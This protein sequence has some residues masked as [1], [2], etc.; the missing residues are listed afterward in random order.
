MLDAP[1]ESEPTDDEFPVDSSTQLKSA[2]RGKAA[3]RRRARR[4]PAD[5]ERSWAD[6]F[7]WPFRKVNSFLSHWGFGQLA[8]IGLGAFVGLLRR[9]MRFR[10]T[11]STVVETDRE[12]EVIAIPDRKTLANPLWWCLWTFQFPLTWLVSRPFVGLVLSVPAVAGLGAAFLVLNRGAQI[13][14]D[15]QA[16]R[17]R[18]EFVAAVE[19]NDL[20]KARFLGDA[21]IR[22]QPESAS[23]LFNLALVEERDGNEEDCAFLMSIA[24]ESLSYEQAALWL[25]NAAG[26]R[27]EIDSWNDQQKSDYERWLKV[28]NE[29]NPDSI[30]TIKALADAQRA[31]GD[32]GAAYETLL[33]I[34]DP[35]SSIKLLLLLLEKELGYPERARKRA[36]ESVQ[37]QLQLLAD[38]PGLVDERILTAKMLVYLEYE[39]RA[40]NLLLQ[41]LK[42]RP[43]GEDRAKLMRAT[44]D[45]Y[46][47]LAD[48]EYKAD[49]SARGLM[50][51]MEYLKTAVS[52]DPASPAVIQAVM[53]ASL[54][55]ANS[56][57]KQIKILR[58]AIVQGVSS[59]AAHFILGT[60]ALIRGE[61]EESKEQLALA[62]E[63][64]PGLPGV[65]N[66]LAYAMCQEDDA[67]L[68]QALQFSQA[69][70][71]QTPGN[72]YVLETR[73]QILFRLERYRE[74][75]PDLEAAL[76]IKDLRK[77]VRPSLA[78]AYEKIGRP[79][80]AKR[81]RDLHA[82]GR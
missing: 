14:E 45:A 16:I 34:E 75:I 48:K 77:L 28:A 49:S 6:I 73:G 24:A 54:D 32:L 42:R 41:G 31:S 33:R 79:A 51:R 12:S 35:D 67:D 39:E 21:I 38:V 44:A 7:L 20:D 5:W 78:L 13:N 26:D 66:N 53:Q 59:D 61:V 69:A 56:G 76:E 9:S 58:E 18:K 10:D 37:Q 50:K 8:G 23:D 1:S 72:A 65:L 3:K 55:A 19:D 57:E 22:L 4:G 30:D 60:T 80:I 62:A 11:R 27:R 15:R 74:A 63:T 46:V 29:S 68:E 47:I 40:K 36:I 70:L 52:A 82:K 25:A 17:L 71:Q 2:S 81:H 64:M 43:T